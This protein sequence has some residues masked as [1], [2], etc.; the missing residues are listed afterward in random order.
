M[1][2]PNPNSPQE[3]KVT[4][5]LRLLLIAGAILFIAL[6][7]YLTPEG[8][9]GKSDAVGYAVCHRI[10]LR[11][12]HLGDR[13]LPLCSR[14]TGMY[15]GALFTLMAFLF[16]RKTSA[17][18][19]RRSIQIALFLFAG[20]WVLDGLNSFLSLIP[21]APSLY[22]PQNWLRLVT[23]TLIGVSLTTLI[24]PVLIATAWKEPD[25]SAVIPTW[26]WFARLLSFLGIVNLGI[27]SE[28]PMILYP[29]ALL[30]SI[31]VLALLTMAYTVLVLTIFRYQNRTMSWRGLWFPLLGGATL[32]LAQ[33]AVIDLLRYVLTG[34]WDGFH[35]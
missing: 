2:E 9:L 10:D 8:L 3:L 20:I 26:G 32:A 27:L 17:S 16:F 23:G 30:S 7:L 4:G 14:C 34:T 13:T 31:G 1:H 11:S 5:I 28:N 33:V 25:R 21:G 19:P 12:F 6:W 18:Y 15:L 35:L 24:Y 29:L 22:M